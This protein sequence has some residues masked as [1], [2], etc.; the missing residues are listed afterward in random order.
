MLTLLIVSKMKLINHIITVI[1]FAN[2]CIANAQEANYPIRLWN[3]DSIKSQI[4]IYKAK[5]QNSNGMGIVVC[6]GGSYSFVSMNNEGNPV[7][8]WLSDNGITAIVLNYRIPNG[9]RALPIEDAREALRY[10]HRNAKNLNVNPY[11]IG[12]WGSSAGGHL[13]ST[14]STHFS[15][16]LSH[17]S[18]QVLYYPVISSRGDLRHSKSFKNLLGENATKNDYS[19]YSNELHVDRMTPATLFI[20]SDD[21]PTVNPM[22]SVVFYE[23]L[24]RYNIPAALYI[25]PIGKHGYG[26]NKDW[27]YQNISRELVLNWLQTIK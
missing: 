1:M 3:E 19:D 27:P 5:K 2:F 24:K 18:F 8:K 9:N 4:T 23:S 21:D 12:I 22:N 25:F 26:F 6:P 7:G 16:S 14:I 20:L 15:D 10:M 17:P 11:K 13:A